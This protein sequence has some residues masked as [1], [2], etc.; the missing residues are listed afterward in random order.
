MCPFPWCVLS[1]WNIPHCFQKLFSCLTFTDDL[2][3]SVS[4]GCSCDFALLFFF[5]NWNYKC[6]V[7]GNL[8]SNWYFLQGTGGIMSTTDTGCLKT[9]CGLNGGAECRTPSLHGPVNSRHC[10]I[11][12]G[13]TI[14]LRMEDVLTSAGCTHKWRHVVV[15]EALPCEQAPLYLH[16]LFVCH[17]FGLIS[18]ALMCN[19]NASLVRNWHSKCYLIITQSNTIT[20]C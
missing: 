16:V 6:K 9:R 13:Q 2:S 5:K 12:Y 10:Y 17:V 8:L 19:A 20:Q 14:A 3:G 7:R 11:Q 4:H 15:G 18:F 1:T